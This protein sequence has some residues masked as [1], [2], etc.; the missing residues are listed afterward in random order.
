MEQIRVSKN[1][2]GTFTWIPFYEEMADKL[3]AFKDNR[4][5]LVDLVYKLEKKFVGYIKTQAGGQLTGIDPFTVFGIFNRGIS[6]CNRIY[7]CQY[8][9]EKL[10]IGASVPTDFDGIPILNNMMAVFHR[11]GDGDITISNLWILFEA[12]M[13]NN[14]S[15]LRTAFDNVRQQYGIRWNITMAL[16]W[17]R[18]NDNLP[19]DS[20]TRE[21]L[22]KLGIDVFDETQF[23]AE[24]YL[25]LISV[26]KQKINDSELSE[27]TFPEI[28]YHAWASAPSLN[29]SNMN[30]NY[31]L[32]GANYGKESQLDRFLKDG[33]W[34]SRYNEGKASDQNLLE[35][36]KTIKKGDVI[37]LKS[38]STKGKEHNQPFLRV[39]GIGIV[40]GDIEQTKFDTFTQCECPVSYLNKVRKDFEGS[41]FGSYRKTIHLADDKA[42]SIIDYALSLIHI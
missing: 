27:K 37:I 25:S 35:L 2:N 33:I 23:D 10:G 8:F 11:S 17:I 34:E 39:S 24:H 9:K 18:P 29:T 22:P 26:V 40:A 28:S 19:L 32:V 4:A 12:A 30:R 42:Q 20:R 41:S 36:V 21:Y 15:A 6:E 14:E 31:W 7:L 13:A 3:L 38:T 1:P 5:V 16:Y